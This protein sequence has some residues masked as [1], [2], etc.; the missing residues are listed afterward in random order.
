MLGAPGPE[1]CAEHLQILQRVDNN[2]GVPPGTKEARMAK[3]MH[4]F[5]RH[6]YR[7]PPPEAKITKG[8]A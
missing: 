5:H 2:L 4:Y 6:Y 1:E 3:Y 7:Y 8:E